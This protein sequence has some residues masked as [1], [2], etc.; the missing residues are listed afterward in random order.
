MA[1]STLRVLSD[2]VSPVTADDL[3]FSE[4]LLRFATADSILDETVGRDPEEVPG[5]APRLV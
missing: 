3:F 5:S 4:W 2:L 1:L